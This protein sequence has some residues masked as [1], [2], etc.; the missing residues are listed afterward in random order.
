MCSQDSCACDRRNEHHNA[1]AVAVGAK[2]Q[3]CDKSV[4]VTRIGANAE[5]EE[6]EEEAEEETEDES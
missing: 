4:C 2:S 3:I 1:T 5:E 6:E